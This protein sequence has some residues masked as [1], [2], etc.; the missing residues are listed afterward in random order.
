MGAT[1]DVTNQPPP[2]VDRDLFADDVALRDAVKRHGVDD[3][4][5]L[6]ALGRIA[7]SADTLEHA[8]LAD[9]NP[10]VLRTHDRYG[11]RIDE[12]E[13]HPSSHA[14]LTTSVKHGLHA[15]AWTNAHPAAH[16]ARA[17]GFYLMSQTEAAHGCP[18]SMTYAAIPALRLDEDVSGRWAPR[19]ADRS[20]PGGALAGM[21]MTEKQGGSDI[22][23]NTS[24]ATRTGDDG[25]YQLTGHKW[26][27]S[28]PMSDVFL[29]L[30]QAPGGV[31]CFVVPRL[32]DD[33]TRN[34]IR[35]QRLKN[36]LGNRANASAEIEFDGVLG[37]RLGDE[38]RGVPTI[39]EMVAATRLDCV[40]G[41]AALMRRAVAEATW[42]AAHRR[43]F[44]QLLSDAPL[45]RN[46]LADLALESEAATALAIRLAASVDDADSEH[47]RAL[48]RLALPVAKFWI[49]K[50]AAAV[51]GEALECLGGNGY[52]EDSGLPRL[53]RE[54]PLN[55]IW[56]GASNIQALDVLRVLERSPDAVEAWQAEVAAAR[57]VVPAFDS[58][59]KDVDLTDQSPGQSRV[60]AY[61]L[62]VLLQGSILIRYA[63]PEVAE[64][65][66]RSHITQSRSVF[67]TLPADVDV[68]EILTRA[69]PLP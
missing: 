2:L 33:G 32:L 14:L 28:A 3:P 6:H 5:T 24:R 18:I 25:W 68:T 10:P 46:V 61:R 7:G 11:H 30:A 54:S 47:E 60:L 20:Y 48:R 9:V 56:E 22:R 19:L 17:A 66:C 39:I 26:F 42:H 23:A 49:C 59:V 51:V 58:A 53:L 36:K 41:S 34:G 63:P 65:F 50:R 8:R 31:T 45:M 43:A 13:F 67:G 62:A 69:T 55:A 44:G 38:G 35:I 52:V 16:V 1:H 37:R 27:C 40:L 15:S 4:Q 21:A 64:A 29:M 12:V 57:G